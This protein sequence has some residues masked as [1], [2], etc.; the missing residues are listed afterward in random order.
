[1]RANTQAIT[2]DGKRVAKGSDTNENRGYM[3]SGDCNNITGNTGHIHRQQAGTSVYET[4]DGEG[5]LHQ[6]ENGN[7]GYG[8]VIVG[9]NFLG[10]STGYIAVC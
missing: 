4:V 2:V 9:N 1:M 3:I 8:D 6:S 7:W 10:G 5:I